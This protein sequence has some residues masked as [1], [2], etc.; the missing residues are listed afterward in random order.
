[1]ISVYSMPYMLAFLKME[2]VKIIQR[3]DVRCSSVL[4]ELLAAWCVVCGERWC[5]GDGLCLAVYL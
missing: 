1:M 2:V 4:D 3:E 5:E